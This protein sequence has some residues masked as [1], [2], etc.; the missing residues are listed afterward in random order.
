MV[1]IVSRGEGLNR[2]G[3]EHVGGTGAVEQ[4]RMKANETPR[5][6]PYPTWTVHAANVARLRVAEKLSVAREHCAAGH[7][8][9]KLSYNS[10]THIAIVSREIPPRLSGRMLCCLAL[11]THAVGRVGD[12]YF[13]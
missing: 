10:R 2:S 8:R 1:H 9:E 13:C 4:H 7:T 12:Q 3:A 5:P 11:K 6:D